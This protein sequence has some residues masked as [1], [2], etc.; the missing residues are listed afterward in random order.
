[1]FRGGL[2]CFLCFLWYS[3]RG[4]RFF[5]V[6]GEIFSLG[7]GWEGM[8]GWVSLLNIIGRIRGSLVVG[9]FIFSVVRG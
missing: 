5:G 8:R 4:G 1:M 7:L 2:G 6:I 9:V 3:G